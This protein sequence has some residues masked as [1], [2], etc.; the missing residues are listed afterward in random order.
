MLGFLNLHLVFK[1][2]FNQNQFN[3]TN[4][5]QEIYDLSFDT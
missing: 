5:K 4:D 2:S 3:V 1:G